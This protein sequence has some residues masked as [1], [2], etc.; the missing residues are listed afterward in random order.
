LCRPFQSPDYCPVD[1]SFAL[2][3]QARKDAYRESDFDLEDYWFPYLD[4]KVG[5]YV[6]TASSDVL[7]PQMYCC[8]TDA[9]QLQDCLDND[10]PSFATGYVIKATHFHTSQGVYVLRKDPPSTNLYEVLRGE[11]LALSD[12]IA[13]LSVLGDTKIIVEELIGNGE[14]DAEFKLHA[15]P[16]EV[17]AIDVIDRRTQGCDCI[18]VVDPAWNRL[19]Q[20]GCFVPSGIANSN[21]DGSCS[22]I[23]FQTGSMSPGPVKKNLNLCGPDIPRPEQCIVND[24]VA[25]AEALS[26]QIG[27]YMRI[28]VFV[29][30]GQVYVQEYS[31][32]PINGL[33]HCVAKEEGDCIDSCL[34]GRK[35][36]GAGLPYGGM[37][38]SVPSLLNDYTDKS[39]ADQCAISSSVTINSSFTSSCIA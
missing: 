24:M 29:S 14:L 21:A 11:N 3:V 15:F 9:S 27:V 22:A 28:D 16:G 6:F 20:F 5:A 26:L 7:T 35:W 13:E 39:P 25:I 36:K 10:V 12:I 34:L 17:V 2:L 30:N 37:A 23:D 18:A 8:L 33:R 38:T 32:N 4:D 1:E 19:D 31:P